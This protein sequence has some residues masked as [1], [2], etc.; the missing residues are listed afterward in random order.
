MTQ[1]AFPPEQ[2]FN[3]SRVNETLA[4][5]RVPSQGGDSDRHQGEA[6]GSCVGT[7][8]RKLLLVDCAVED[9]QC[10]LNRCAHSVLSNQLWYLSS[11]T[12]QL[13]SSW[14][15]S[16]IPPLLA[17]SRQPAKISSGDVSSGVISSSSKWGANNAS[18]VNIPLCVASSPN[19]HRPTRIRQPPQVLPLRGPWPA[20]QVWAGPLSGGSVTVIPSSC[21]KYPHL[22]SLKV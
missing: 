3:L 12:G 11:K 6:M 19:P 15:H 14:T 13:I 10:Q 1:V 8:G 5:I 2:V 22:H 17:P 21:H 9:P 4:Q 16:A 18:L 7:D 20:Q